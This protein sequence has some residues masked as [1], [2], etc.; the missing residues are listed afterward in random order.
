MSNDLVVGNWRAGLAKHAADWVKG[1]EEH[2][3][4]G[5]RLIGDVEFGA[6]LIQLLDSYDEFVGMSEDEPESEE[7][8]KKRG[9]PPKES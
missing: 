1:V 2:Q 7:L 3:E 4:K 6:Q 5:F 8:P 9:R